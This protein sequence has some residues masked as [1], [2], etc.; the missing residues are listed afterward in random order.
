MDL[1]RGLQYSDEIRIVPSGLL[2]AAD[3][4]RR[5]RTEVELAM[6]ALLGKQV[7]PEKAGSSRD[8]QSLRKGS[9]EDKS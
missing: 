1:G 2:L 6:K 8:R 7:P 5:R 4:S 9:Q 3:I